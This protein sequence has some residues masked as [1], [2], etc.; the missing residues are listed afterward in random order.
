MKQREWKQGIIR[1]L[2]IFITDHR[3]LLSL[4]YMGIRNPLSF[5]RNL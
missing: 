5:L 2:I 3:S 4:Y 1:M